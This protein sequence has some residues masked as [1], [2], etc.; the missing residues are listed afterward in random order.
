MKLACPWGLATPRT[1]VIMRVT[2]STV[3]SPLRLMTGTAA[4]MAYACLQLDW[5]LMETMYGAMVLLD[6]VENM[7]KRVTVV[8]RKNLAPASS[9]S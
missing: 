3:E 2:T 5:L 4:K 6:K 7:L 9:V 8:G 1:L